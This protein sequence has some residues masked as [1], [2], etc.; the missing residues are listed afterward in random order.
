MKVRCSPRAADDLSEILAYLDER[1]PRGAQ[2]V[3]QAIHKAIALIGRHPQIGRLYQSRRNTCVSGR[4]IPIFDFL[5]HRGGRS[6]DRAHPPH[7]AAPVGRRAG[8]PIT[9]KIGRDI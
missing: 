5:E 7:P 3:K 9:M 4:A 2:N 1:S 6:L 8:R